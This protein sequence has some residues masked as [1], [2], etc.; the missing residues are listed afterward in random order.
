M[1]DAK[2]VKETAPLHPIPVKP[3]VWRQVCLIYMNELIQKLRA[4]VIS[5]SD[6]EELDATISPLMKA[7]SS[8]HFTI[9]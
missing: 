3:K 7:K 5:E 9:R 6:D 2:F 1:I 4:P 8:N